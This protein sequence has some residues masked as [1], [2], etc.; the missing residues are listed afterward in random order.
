[1][2]IHRHALTRGEWV[3]LYGAAGGVGSL[4][5]HVAVAQGAQVIV[6]ARAQH[7]ALHI[8]RQERWPAA[9][10]RPRMWRQ[11]HRGSRDG[12]TDAVANGVGGETVAQSLAVLR[13]HGRAASSV[14]V[15]FKTCCWT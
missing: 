12:N 10:T 5:L 7:H 11:R 4:A 2:I 15:M 14:G 1:M 3:L 13:P 8:S 6:I 9:T